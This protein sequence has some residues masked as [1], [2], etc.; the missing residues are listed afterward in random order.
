ME[1]TKRYDEEGRVAVLISPGFGAGWSTWSRGKETE[2][3]L[4]DSRLVDAILAEMP[5]AEFVAYCESL[6][7]DHY[8]GGAEDLRVVWL[9]PGTRFLVEDYDGSESIRTFDDL[10]FVA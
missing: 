3:L 2:A 10:I 4:F 7:Y 5:E 8:K 6:G 1:Y 9:E